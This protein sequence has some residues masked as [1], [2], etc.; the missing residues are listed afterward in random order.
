MLYILAETLFFSDYTN[1]VS[2]MIAAFSVTTLLQVSYCINKQSDVKSFLSYSSA[3]NLP[4]FLAIFIGVSEKNLYKPYLTLIDRLAEEIYFQSIASIFIYIFLYL[5]NFVILTTFS[6]YINPP[7]HKSYLKNKTYF[8]SISIILK[9]NRTDLK[10][11]VA[12]L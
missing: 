3:A 8:T 5:V 1:A 2:Y 10:S 4:I 9:E 11:L 12:V 6:Y 7:K